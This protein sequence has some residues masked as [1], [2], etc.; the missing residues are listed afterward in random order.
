MIIIKAILMLILCFI[1]IFNIP[2]IV[3][4]FNDFIIFFEWVFKIEHSQ[5]TSM[6]V[7][8]VLVKVIIG[9]ITIITLFSCIKFFIKL[10]LDL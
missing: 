10:A 7:S 4:I 6:F 1:G 8:D 5:S 3:D 9:C 2:S